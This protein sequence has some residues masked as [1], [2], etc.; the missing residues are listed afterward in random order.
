MSEILAQL[1]ETVPL[2][3]VLEDGNTSKFPQAKIY[4]GTGTAVPITSITLVHK[5]SGYYYG[6]YLVPGIA[7]FTVVYTVF[8]DIAHTLPSVAYSKADDYIV[9][10]MTAPSVTSIVSALAEAQLIVSYEDTNLIFRSA[11][12]MDRGGAT[13]TTP[14]VATI[15]V[16]DQNNT[17]LFTQTSL[18]PFPNGVFYFQ[19]GSVQLPDNRIFYVEV[20]VTDGLGTV[21]T[22]QTFTTV[23]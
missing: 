10:N 19:Q 15:H 23:G 21:Q 17:L 5:D 16:R 2:V 6:S 18:A 9:S 8:D 3:L 1:G 4:D 20:S 11:C 22:I 14:F 12:W 7:K 13:V